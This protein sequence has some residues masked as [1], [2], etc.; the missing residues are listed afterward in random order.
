MKLAIFD[1]DGTLVPKDALPFVLNQWKKQKYPKVK[2]YRTYFSLICLYIRYKSGIN[3][4]MSRE[5]MRVVAIKKFNH[6]FHGMSEE[7]ISKFFFNCSEEIIPL[8]DK[9]VVA[10]IEVCRSDGYHMILL[11]GAHYSL[12][13]YVGENL[14]FDTVIGTKLHFSNNIFDSDKEVEVISGGMKKEKIHEYFHDQL[15]DWRTS[16][17][18]ADSYFDIDLL[19]SVGQ[20]VAVNP[21]VKLKEIAIERN[22]RVIN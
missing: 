21:D 4:K 8:L 2:Y 17:A 12:L 15:V 1:F 19:E 7:E 16:R 6:I 20:P 9:N 11:S 14:G 3:F 18:F 10:E 5:K 22:W 13:K